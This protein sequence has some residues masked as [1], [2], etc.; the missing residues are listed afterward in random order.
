[1]KKAGGLIFKKTGECAVFLLPTGK[2]KIGR[3]NSSMFTADKN[4][5]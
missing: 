5:S 1:M 3:M 2:S 4:C